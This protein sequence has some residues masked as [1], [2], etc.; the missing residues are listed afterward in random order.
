MNGCLLS[1]RSMTES[2]CQRQSWSQRDVISG[3]S[4]SSVLAMEWILF[5][6]VPEPETSCLTRGKLGI[7][8]GPGISFLISQFP[9]ACSSPVLIL[10]L[11]PWVR[12]VAHFAMILPAAKQ[13]EGNQC[14]CLPLVNLDM[15]HTC[16]AAGSPKSLLAVER[17]GLQVSM[18]H[19]EAAGKLEVL[20][21]L[22]K[23]C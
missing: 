1:V 11:W 7:L 8:S 10:H 13:M 4:T 5:P 19:L 22:L 9:F 3:I 15:T 16:P 6:S 12:D 2:G 14:H 20:H 23:K 17:L 21:V 18:W